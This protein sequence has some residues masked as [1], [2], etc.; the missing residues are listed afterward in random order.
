MH[1]FSENVGGQPFERFLASCRTAHHIT[2]GGDNLLHAHLAIICFQLRQLLKAQGYAHLVASGCTYQS[3]YL[4]EVECRQLVHDDAHRD[5]LALPCVHSC[6]QSVE[7]EGVQC[8][9]DALHLWVVGYQQIAWIL[10]VA[11]LQVEVITILV[12]Y[13]IAFLGGKT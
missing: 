11:D 2:Y 13:P 7:D 8:S 5:V 1:H 10:R 6:H 4:M 3:V 9:D 12:E